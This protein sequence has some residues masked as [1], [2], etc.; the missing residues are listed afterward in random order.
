MSIKDTPSVGEETLWTLSTTIFITLMAFT[1]RGLNFI[2]VLGAVVYA[3]RTAYLG[4]RW[5]RSRESIDSTTSTTHS[6]LHS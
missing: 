2:F 5:Y 4:Y 6:S 1:A 3:V